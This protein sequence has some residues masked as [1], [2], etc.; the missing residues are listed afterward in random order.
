M[1][2][3]P[4]GQ[5]V[6]I[7]RPQSW[8]S[9]QITAKT[10]LTVKRYVFVSKAYLY[11]DE[12]NILSIS[13]THLPRTKWPPFRRQDFRCIFVNENFYILIQISLKFVPKGPIHKHCIGSDNGLAPNRRQ[14][15]IWTNAHRIHWCMQGSDQFISF[16]SIQFQF[17]LDSGFFNSIQFQFKSDSVSFNS[18][19]IPIH[20]LSIPIQ[21]NSNVMHRNKQINQIIGYFKFNLNISL[22]A[23]QFR[24]YIIQ[25]HNNSRINKSA[26]VQ[27][28]G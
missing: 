4:R 16:N 27:V 11:I 25:D 10:M 13:L 5:W 20:F 24:K 9:Q 28:L 26:L 19:P 17:K 6:N 14:A 12:L 8:S 7:S 1:F 2:I 21:F 3:S 23:A 22:F 18:I 15:I